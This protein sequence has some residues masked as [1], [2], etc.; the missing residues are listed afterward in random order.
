MNI[1]DIIIILLLIMFAIVG[2][3]KG[4]IEEVVSL[5]GI[6]L[7]FVISFYLKGYVG[8]FLCKYLPFFNFSSNLKGMVTLNI[9]LYQLIGFFIVYGILFGIY[10]IILKVSGIIQKLLNLTIIFILPSK[11]LGAVV[12]LISGYITLFIILL[13]LYIPLHN[14]ELFA[15]SNMVNK[16]IYETPILSKKTSNISTSITEIY[17]LTDAVGNNK[18]SINDANL[19]ALDIMLKHKVVD[20]KTVEQLIVLDKLKDVHNIDSIV[21]KY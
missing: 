9:L 2:F 17:D 7:V 5:V 16:I 8:N 19:K 11:I 15:G 12:A 4:V 13:T 3:K 6:I 21:N 20:K 18:I 14:N 10:Q 1:F